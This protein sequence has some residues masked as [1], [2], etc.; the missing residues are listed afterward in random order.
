MQEEPGS[1]WPGGPPLD[2]FEDH[3][4]Y[5]YGYGLPP[6]L[7]EG[8]LRRQRQ[9][10]KDTLRRQRHEQM[11]KDLDFNHVLRS[12]ENSRLV[13]SLENLFYP[14]PP[15]RH[16]PGGNVFNFTL[17]PLLL[18]ADKQKIYANSDYMKVHHFSPCAQIYIGDPGAAEYNS[19]NPPLLIA[20]TIEQQQ[21]KLIR[22]GRE[23]DWHMCRLIQVVL[24]C[25]ANNA[26]FD[27]AASLVPN[28]HI[29]MQMGFLR[30]P[31]LHLLIIDIYNK[32]S[33]CAQE[34]RRLHPNLY[35]VHRERLKHM[36][37]RGA[38]IN[39]GGTSNDYNALQIAVYLNLADIVT[40]LL[41][42]SVHQAN[43]RVCSRDRGSSLFQLLISG[44][45]YRDPQSPAGPGTNPNCISNF[46]ICLA[47]A[48]GAGLIDGKHSSQIDCIHAKDVKNSSV[49]D[50]LQG[51]HRLSSN[52][53][54]DFN[55]AHT[56]KHFILRDLFFVLQ[57]IVT[58]R[59]NIRVQGILTHNLHS[60]EWER[61]VPE[62]IR[63]RLIREGKR[64]ENEEYFIRGE[65]VQRYREHMEQHDIE[66]QLMSLYLLPSPATMPQ[67]PDLQAEI[68][69]HPT[70]WLHTLREHALHTY[71]AICNGTR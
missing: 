45:Y 7:D 23:Q 41:Q 8:T 59:E 49:M 34:V 35:M 6:Q 47:R 21:R 15:S 53:P 67:A 38:D 29:D 60:K 4:N 13:N 69:Q 51:V 18:P 43:M 66:Q 70:A 17:N 5:D 16:E 64:G 57:D 48:S 27:E 30:R 68:I 32:R 2:F 20:R 61:R 24:S 25:E 46:L 54:R 62:E 1:A 39:M 11:R 36:L 3:E 33:R 28:F 63:R 50:Y 26:E 19:K 31:L 58:I 22:R 44:Y 12:W 14:L 37:K 65:M 56:D 10:D 55:S 9:L 42:Y 40:D 52:F 71:T